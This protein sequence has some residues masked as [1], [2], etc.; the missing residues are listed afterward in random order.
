[1][2]INSGELRYLLILNNYDILPEFD[3]ELLTQAWYN[4]YNEFSETVGGN[5]ADLWLMKQKG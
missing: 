2:V 3:Q 4:I 1:M 5:R